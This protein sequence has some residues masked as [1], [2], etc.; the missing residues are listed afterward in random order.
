M[1]DQNNDGTFTRKSRPVGKGLTENSQPNDGFGTLLPF[2]T[3]E[4]DIIFKP[5]KARVYTFDLTC[6]S[7]I[8]R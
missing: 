8:N 2:E 1:H 7:M 5:P 3:L 6:K 4:L